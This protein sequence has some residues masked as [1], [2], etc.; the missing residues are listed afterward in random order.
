V[1]FEGIKMQKKQ[2][3]QESI[4]IE[5]MQGFL[6]R[7]VQ[8]LVDNP[9]EVTV[10]PMTTAGT[11]YLRLSVS[12]SDMSRIIGQQGRTARAIRVLLNAASTKF[13]LRFA[14][15]IVERQLPT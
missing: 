7:I 4:A 1:A 5:S 8:A 11:T 6:V 10:Q 12:P 2:T 15:D 3:M 14:L 13:E 9:V